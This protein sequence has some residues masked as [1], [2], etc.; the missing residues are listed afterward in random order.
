MIKFPRLIKVA[1]QRIFRNPSNALAAVLVMFSAF[2]ICGAFVLVTV[3]SGALLH[4][5]ESRPEVT[6][7]LKDNT[8]GD[9]VKKI[10]QTLSDSGVVSKTKYVSKEEA[11]RIYK[12]RNKN[13]PLLTQFVTSDI[14]PASIEVSTYK[15]A[16]LSKV[17]EVL[18]KESS[19]EEV[20]FEKDIVNTLTKWSNTI[21][22][23]GIGVVIFL[24]LTSF[25]I[26][27]I[28]IGLNISIHKDEIEIMRLVG[29]TSWYIRTPF[30][31]EGVFYGVF[32]GLVAAML[33]F[34]FFLW[35]SPTLHRT[36]AGIDILPSAPLI[37]IYLL[38]GEFLIGAT[39]GIIG[40]FVATRKY[41]SS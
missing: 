12:E 40:S 20:V 17:A 15:L 10:Q 36:F 9:Q 31:L 5:F 33:L 41:L 29:A 25:L 18:K 23:V 24:L 30:I 6:A 3:A 4:Y 27:L 39:I 32:S 2:F 8:T 35:A 11:L 38:L 19:V 37:F 16:D 28:V 22:L 14:L 7:F 34:S 13:E 26:T 21:R 1:I